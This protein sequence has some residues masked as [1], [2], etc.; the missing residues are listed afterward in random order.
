MNK[1]M[2]RAMVRGYASGTVVSLVL[3]NER[4]MSVTNGEDGGDIIGRENQQ[5]RC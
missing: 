5:R 2:M 4:L 1:D 3:Y